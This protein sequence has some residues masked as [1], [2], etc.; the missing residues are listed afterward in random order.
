MAGA[1]N[2]TAPRVHV[3]VGVIEDDAGRVLVAWRPPGSHQGDRWE[4]PGGKVEPGETPDRALARELREETGLHVA[5]CEPLIRIPHDYP[6]KRVLLHVYRVRPVDARAVAN[7]GQALYWA[8]SEE[9]AGLRFPAANAAIVTAARLPRTYAISPDCDHPEDGAWWRGLEAAIAAG[10]RLFQYRV[11]SLAHRDEHAAAA[12]RRIQAAGGT[13][14]INGD[15]ALAVRAGADGVHLPAAMIGA[16][17]YRP[18]GW[19]AASCHN[20]EELARAVA[21]GVDFAVLGPVAMTA[22]HPD[23]QPLGWERFEAWVADLPVP[24]YAL[25]GL[26]PQDADAACRSGGQGV[27]GITGFWPH[28]D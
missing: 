6:D 14:L 9:L 20:T 28:A 2:G 16:V 5:S 7:H 24:V 11:P 1:E 10:H 18:P 17:S 8:R 26:S 25:G 22:S 27:A 4:F 15:P 23:R 19:L 3:A 12:V 21:A 13:C